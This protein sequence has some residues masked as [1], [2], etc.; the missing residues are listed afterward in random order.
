MDPGGTL[1]HFGVASMVVSDG[2]SSRLENGSLQ[3]MFKSTVSL[4]VGGWV[5]VE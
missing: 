4:V 3:A 2:T 1:G 5:I